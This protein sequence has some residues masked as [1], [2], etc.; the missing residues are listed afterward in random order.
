MDQI[1]FLP[2]QF[3]L[4]SPCKNEQELLMKPQLVEGINIQDTATMTLPCYSYTI[5]F[6]APT[7]LSAF[8]KYL[9]QV[10]G[11][12]TKLA[13]HASYSLF[14]QRQRS[15]ILAYSLCVP[16]SKTL[17]LQNANSLENL[18]S[19]LVPLNAKQKVAFS[20]LVKLQTISDN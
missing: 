6:H 19:S 16:N 20:R 3:P 9:W 8:Y 17:S 1:R 10:S 13:N 7:I 2:G 14:I 15:C 12:K 4:Y 11:K 18:S 5:T